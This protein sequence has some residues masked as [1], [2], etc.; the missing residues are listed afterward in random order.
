MKILFIFKEG[1][2]NSCR[3]CRLKR[4]IEV[5]MKISGGFSDSISRKVEPTNLFNNENHQ[6]KV[7]F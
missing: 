6:Q 3:A 4:C 2:R 7:R 5:G 1:M